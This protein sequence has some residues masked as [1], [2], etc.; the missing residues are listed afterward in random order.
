V[1]EELPGWEEPLTGARQWNDL[2][3]AAQKFIYRIAELSQVG[4]HSV[5]V[6]P[7]RDQVVMV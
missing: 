3:A 6:G 2:P 7:E 5:S 1:L 4:V